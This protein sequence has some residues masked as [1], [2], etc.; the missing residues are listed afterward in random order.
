MPA[1]PE[2]KYNEEPL[3]H[4]ATAPNEP[5]AQMW[6]GILEDN[7]VPCMVKGGD[8]GASMYIPQ[9]QLQQQIW[10]LESDAE[11]AKEILAPFTEEEE[12]YKQE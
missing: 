2:D 8:L 12:K 7:N 10:V 11:R 9:F 1:L 4:I 5:I 6:A 3:V